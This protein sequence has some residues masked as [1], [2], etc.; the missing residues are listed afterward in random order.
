MAF[1]MSIDEKSSPIGLTCLK[2]KTLYL[3]KPSM[4]EMIVC[5]ERKW[6]IMSICMKCKLAEEK[7]IC[8]K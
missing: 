4:N 8:S 2:C 7:E 1:T 3:A 5:R 6:V